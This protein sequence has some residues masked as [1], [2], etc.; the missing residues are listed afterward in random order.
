MLLSTVGFGFLAQ[1]DF[2]LKSFG[3]KLNLIQTKNLFKEIL[4]QKNL[5]QKNLGQRKI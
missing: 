3:S 4:V 1:N 2:G 5:V